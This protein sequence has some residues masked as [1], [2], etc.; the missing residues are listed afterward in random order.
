[1]YN[2]KLNK[3]STCDCKIVRLIHRLCDKTL[4]S[5][6]GWIVGR[7]CH[8]S[9]SSIFERESSSV[10]RMKQRACY[11]QTNKMV[12]RESGGVFHRFLKQ[13]LFTLQI[14]IFQSLCLDFCCDCSKFWSV[15]NWSR[16]WVQ[17]YSHSSAAETRGW[18]TPD[19]DSDRNQ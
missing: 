12:H 1:M 3:L 18:S 17:F 11:K 6:S 8:G 13:V 16:D 15:V 7:G 10:F 2:L 9:K 5:Y 14:K 4:Y 19:Y